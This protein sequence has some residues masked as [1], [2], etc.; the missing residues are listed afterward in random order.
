MRP[1]SKVCPCESQLIP[2]SQAEACIA[3]NGEWNRKRHH[4][5]SRPRCVEDVELDKTTFGNNV[6]LLSPTLD[7]QTRE[8]SKSAW[9]T[10]S[11]LKCASLGTELACGY[12]R[13]LHFILAHHLFPLLSIFHPS[14]LRAVIADIYTQTPLSLLDY[15][16]MLTGSSS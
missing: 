13:R 14:L 11:K 5:S 7:V 16:D 8:F 2:A 4:D 10:L 1:F 9:S 12:C 15:P 6:S 3:F